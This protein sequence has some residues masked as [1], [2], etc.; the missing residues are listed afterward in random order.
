MAALMHLPPILGVVT[1]LLTAPITALLGPKSGPDRRHCQRYG[2]LHC[3]R[4]EG[5]GNRRGC[6]GSIVA[7][8]FMMVFCVLRL[9]RHV[10]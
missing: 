7:A 9:G 2:S 8:V 5:T 10:F 1:S 4:G 3:E 6:E